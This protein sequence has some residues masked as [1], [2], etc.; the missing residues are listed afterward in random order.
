QKKPTPPPR[1]ARQ[2]PEHT[3]EGRPGC[4]PGES[5][6]FLSF[7]FSLENGVVLLLTLW[8]LFRWGKTR[9]VNS[10]MIAV[11]L[12]TVV[13]ALLLALSTPN[14]GSLA[15]YKTGFMPFF[16]YLILFNHPVA[17]ALQR[18]LKFL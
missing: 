17:Q 2:R 18:R 9:Q 8:S 15:R 1:L 12:Y 5:F 11:L 13:L 6:N 7:F 4:M 10:W 16:V 3:A 14:F